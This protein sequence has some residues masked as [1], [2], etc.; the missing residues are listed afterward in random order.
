MAN[1]S[2]I[3]FIDTSKEV[4][5]AL[6]GLSKTAL[7]ASGKVV[8][9]KLRENMAKRTKNFKNHIGTWVFIGKDTGIPQMQ[10]GFY[11][12]Q[13]VKKRGKIPSRAN[14]HWIEKGTKAH[15][16]SVKKAK[17]MAYEENIY[18]RTVNHPGQHA[19]HVLRE[20]VQNNISEIRAA[21][22]EYLAEM[23]RTIEEIAPKIDIG[24]DFEDDD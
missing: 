10:V 1:K 6:E 24:D 8:R 18:G 3:T 5:K 14:P 16:I 7:R 12:W 9:K 19:Q 20:T 13:R 21:Q 15:Q 23:K 11:S 4:K 17:I 22:A 2:T